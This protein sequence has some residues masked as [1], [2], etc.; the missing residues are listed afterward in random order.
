[1]RDTRRGGRQ[2]M[3]GVEEEISKVPEITLDFQ[4]V[5]FRS[6]VPKI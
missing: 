6:R 1:M 3:S 2:R 4:G 5:P